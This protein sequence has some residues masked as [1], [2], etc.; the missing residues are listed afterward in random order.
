MTYLFVY[1]TLRR[2]E[3]ADVSK[4]CAA[5]YVGVARAR[6][7]MFRVED[8]PGMVESDD[9]SDKV[10]G[11]VYRLEDALRAWPVLDEYEGDEFERSVTSVRMADGQ[12]LQAWAYFYRGDTSQKDRISSGDYPRQ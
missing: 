2:G 1:G 7:K 3:R 5:T 12:I 9:E 8:H 11:E 4:K 10:I 6:G